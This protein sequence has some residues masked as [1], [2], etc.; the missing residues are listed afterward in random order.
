MIYKINQI[1]LKMNDQAIQRQIQTNW[2]KIVRP[3]SEQ[4]LGDANYFARIDTGELIK[5]SLRSS[6]LGAGLLVWDTRYATR[7]YYTGTPSRDKNAN[8]SLRWVEVA[9]KM[10]SDQW[11]KLAQKELLR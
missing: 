8:A 7:V 2:Q 3:L 10:Y 9:G 1:N 6:D 4:I 5:S 11:L